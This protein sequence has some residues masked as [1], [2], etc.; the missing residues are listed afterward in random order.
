MS[1]GVVLM[2]RMNG[3]LQ[4]HGAFRRPENGRVVGDV[5]SIHAAVMMLRLQML[6]MQQRAVMLLLQRRG[7]GLGQQLGLP[8]GQQKSQNG[9]NESVQNAD[10]GEDVGPSNLAGAG[11]V[12]AG[13]AAA[14]FAYFD[15]IPTGRI[16]DAAEE[17]TNAA[18]DLK[19]TANVEDDG[20]VDEDEE[21]HAEETQEDDERREA[22]E[23]RRR[24]KRRG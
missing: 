5:S 13:A 19:P 18:D 23:K 1:E 7:V 20:G 22:D 2:L 11:V 12:F 21:D 14:N 10:Y 17:E 16:N 8:I 4:R 6:R 24:L 9:Q 15:V 3:R